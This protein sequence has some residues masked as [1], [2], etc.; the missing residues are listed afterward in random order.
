MNM[1]GGLLILKNSE[2]RIFEGICISECEFPRPSHFDYVL[3]MS[4]Y[5]N[6]VPAFIPFLW[7]ATVLVLDEDRIS[8]LQLGQWARV[9]T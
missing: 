6:Y 1:S 7:E 2:V 5:F 3:V 8:R 9:L 4:T